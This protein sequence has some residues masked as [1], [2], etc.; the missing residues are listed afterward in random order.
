MSGTPD[1]G[2]PREGGTR[3]IHKAD[4]STVTIA[5]DGCV[6]IEKPDGERV[7]HWPDGR[8]VIETPTGERIEKMRKLPLRERPLNVSS[9]SG[10]EIG[11]L[12]SNFAPTPFQLDSKRYASIESFY[13]CLKF[14]DNPKKQQEIRRMDGKSARR[15]GQESKATTARYGGQSFVLGSREHHQIVQ[16]AIRAKLEQNP[17]I[18][19]AF[20][21]TYPR[22][23]VH[24]TGHAER[25]NTSL[26]AATFVRMLTELRDELRSLGKR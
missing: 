3:I 13:V 9:T 20:A 16:C 23:I 22:P 19:E 8:C 11:Q 6:E 14:S 4:G 7:T 26:P 2:S 1:S 5:A 18:A 10:E 17:E 12:M 21:A 25:A 15:A 24:D